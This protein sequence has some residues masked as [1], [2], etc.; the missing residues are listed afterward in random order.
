MAPPKNDKVSKEVA[1]LKYQHKEVCYKIQRS[2]RGEMKAQ[3]QRF[4]AKFD[5]MTDMLV[6][7]MEVVGR[8]TAIVEQ[9]AAERKRE[10]VAKIDDERA[11]R[12]EMKKVVIMTASICVSITALAFTI[13]INL[14]VIGG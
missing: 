3:E 2:V 8:T 12:W 9:L 10:K 7:Q 13:L 11:E 4:N 14:N 1:D 5:K 6:D